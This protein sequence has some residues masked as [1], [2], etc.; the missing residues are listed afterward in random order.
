MNLKTYRIDTLALDL[1]KTKGRIVPLFVL[2]VASEAA[3]MF[4]MDDPGSALAPCALVA[5]VLFFWLWLRAVVRTRDLLEVA[6]IVQNLPREVIATI[7]PFLTIETRE[8]RNRGDRVFDWLF[9]RPARPFFRPDTDT[10]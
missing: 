4:A 2:G 10:L 5:T 7:W 6:R 9:R 8:P 3:A 1:N